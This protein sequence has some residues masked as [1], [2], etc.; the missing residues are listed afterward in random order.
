MSLAEDLEEAMLSH[1]QH[2]GFA[3]GRHTLVLGEEG[4]QLVEVDN[5]AVKLVPLQMVGP[6]SDFAEVTG[7]VFV[8]VDSVMMLTTGVTAT[9]GMLAVL[10]DAAMAMADVTAQLSRLLGLLFRHFFLNEKVYDFFK[11]N[12]NF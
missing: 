11:K 4:D 1:V 2:G 5:G 9:T 12:S 7:M 6:H 3:L 10:A 8:E